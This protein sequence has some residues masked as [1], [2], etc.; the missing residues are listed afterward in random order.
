MFVF[1][2]FVILVVA[3]FYFRKPR[4][5]VVLTDPITGYRKYLAEVDGINNSFNYSTE[6]K[7][8]IIFSDVNR[9]IQF[10]SGVNDNAKPTIEYKKNFGWKKYNNQNQ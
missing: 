1:I 10:I 5:R 8:A 4:Y 9:A 3:F 6:E 2:I 7:S